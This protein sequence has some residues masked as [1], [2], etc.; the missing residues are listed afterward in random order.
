M[1]WRIALL[2]MA[3]VS[4]RTRLLDETAAPDVA[5]VADAQSA[6]DAVAAQDL[7]CPPAEACIPIGFACCQDRYCC[8]ARCQGG[9]CRALVLP[10]DLA[11]PDMAMSCSGLGDCVETGCPCLSN[12]DCCNGLVCS[13]PPGMNAGVCHQP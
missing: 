12:S 5:T 8:S 9:I 4:C 2:L 3:G 1:A 10:P 6:S 13:V 7:A 11:I